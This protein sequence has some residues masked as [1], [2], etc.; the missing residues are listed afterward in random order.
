MLSRAIEIL[1]HA[2]VQTAK[3]YLA[4]PR[5][6]VDGTAYMWAEKI[7]ENAQEEIEKELR[8]RPLD[9][10]SARSFRSRPVAEN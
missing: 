5:R 9:Y 2:K 7:I 1:E 8:H 10:G 3:S 4:S 6:S